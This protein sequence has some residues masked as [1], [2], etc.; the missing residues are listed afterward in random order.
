MID[1]RLLAYDY[2]LPAEQIALYPL[3]SRSASR[4]LYLQEHSLTDS[5][6]IELPHLL[7]EGDMLVFNNTKVLNARVTGFRKT[8][9]KL[10]LFFLQEIVNPNGC[11]QH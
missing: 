4:M 2:H 10:E 1:P 8:G 3:A 9:G 11:F 7:R 6:V 5:T